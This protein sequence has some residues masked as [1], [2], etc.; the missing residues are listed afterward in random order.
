MIYDVATLIWKEWKEIFLTRGTTRR[1]I[2]SAFVI[3]VGL[4]GVF[5]P[6]QEGR[7]WA[8]S[9]ITAVL[10]V[11]LPVF[12]VSTLICESF[13]GERERKTLET[14]LASRLDDRTILFG[15]IAAAVCYG[16]AI[17]LA[18]LGLGFITVNVVHAH[19][20]PILLPP[21]TVFAVTTISL[22][23]SA[24]VASAGVL[25]S[26]RASTVRQAQQTMSLSLLAVF[27][28]F[29]FGFSALPASWRVWFLSTFAGANLATT[30]LAAC[31]ALLALDILLIGAAVAR[32]QRARLILD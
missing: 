18:C 5:M 17:G 20:E 29:G 23:A 8:D 24:L 26:L 1:G 12:L 19:G 21:L 30:I 13:A 4:V 7:A 3:P 9:L 14:L 11:W 25:I 28:G 31:A 15:K 6:W 16:W 32:F 10:W 22:L 2:L 27:F